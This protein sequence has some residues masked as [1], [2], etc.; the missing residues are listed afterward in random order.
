MARTQIWVLL[1]RFHHSEHS[2]HKYAFQHWSHSFSSQ[3]AITQPAAKRI[4][5][6]HSSNYRIIFHAL[7]S[8]HL[9][10]TLKVRRSTNSSKVARNDFDWDIE[11]EDGYPIIA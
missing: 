6:T 4:Q 9:G 2:S 5:A 1:A 10:F 3:S 8:R 11:P 7:P